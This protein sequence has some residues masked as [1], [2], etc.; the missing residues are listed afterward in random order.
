MVKQG[1]VKRRKGMAMYS[2]VWQRAV[3]AWLGN[4]RSGGAAAGRIPWKTIFQGIL[5]SFI[6]GE[7]EI[8][9]VNLSPQ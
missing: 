6:F 5:Q 7:K 1:G 9:Y 2:T 3:T 4:V 8:I